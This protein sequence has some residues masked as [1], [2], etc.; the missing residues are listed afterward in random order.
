MG[1]VLYRLG[2]LRDLAFTGVASFVAGLVPGR[3]A[4]L[5]TGFW[6]SGTTWLQTMMA[7]AFRARTIFEPLSPRHPRWWHR[8]RARAPGDWTDADIQ[9]WIPRLD[10]GD[11][12]LGP[13][14]HE[15]IRGALAGR[16]DSP[17]SWVARNGARETFRSRVVV[18]DVRCSLSLR[19]IHETH[20]VPIVHL[21]R[22][23]CAVLASFRRLRW[24]WS[25][26]DV[27][28]ARTLGTPGFDADALTRIAACWAVTE[29]RV[30]RVLG[31]APWAR[32][33]EYES[34]IEDPE[35]ALDGIS[36]F[37]GWSREAEADPDPA[38]RV[39]DSDRRDLPAKTRRDGWRSELTPAEIARVER[40]VR[41]LYP[42]FEGF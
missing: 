3:R 14:I 11:V 29:A 34:V 21:R 9:A 17:Y 26:D 27:S 15:R 18:K 41:R 36:T 33:L 23:P 8:L 6:R 37:L 25:F 32:V 19:A 28:L 30:D 4:C 20:G 24:P 7:E 38:T 1:K 39:T 12:S 22:H 10:D 13:R 42:A 2:K 31:R 40:I 5:V 35:A 16:A